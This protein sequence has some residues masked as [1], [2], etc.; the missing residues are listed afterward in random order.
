MGDHDDGLSAENNL[1]R[2]ALSGVRD[3]LIY[4]RDHKC[5]HHVENSADQW[6]DN[7]RL[8]DDEP[9]FTCTECGK[10]G[11]DIRPKFSRAKMGTE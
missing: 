5:G 9:S 8:S 11:A 10:R 6:P 4:C 3:V 1:R 2:G 7:I